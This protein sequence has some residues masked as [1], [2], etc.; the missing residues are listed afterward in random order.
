MPRLVLLYLVSV[1]TGFAAA[2]VFV[3]LLL[4]FD[5]GGLSGLVRGSPA[6]WIGGVML[7]VFNGIVFAGVQ[8]GIAVMAMGE[9]V[10]DRRGPPRDPV[11]AAVP[12]RVTARVQR[13]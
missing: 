2:L 3:A 12:V 6:G 10:D 7:V 11:P 13:R 4:A 8:F 9:G 1:A 5:I